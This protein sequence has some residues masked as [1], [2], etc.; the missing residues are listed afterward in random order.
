M[1][2]IPYIVH[3]GE[4]ITLPTNKDRIIVEKKTDDKLYI[5]GNKIQVDGWIM[6]YLYED[7]S[8]IVT[9]D[10][11]AI[12]IEVDGVIASTAAPCAYVAATEVYVIRD[13]RSKIEVV[14]RA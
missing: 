2:S 3:D 1:K 5:Y 4:I 8:I 12:I 13:F 11:R 10:D 6:I 9:H 7:I 14:P